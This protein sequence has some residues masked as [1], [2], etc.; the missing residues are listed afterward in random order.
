LKYV[1]CGEEIMKGD[2]SRDS[3]DRLKH[4]RR[5]LMQQGR[6]QLDSD[7]NEQVSILLHYIQTLATDIIGPYA[8]PA[9]EDWGFEIKDKSS[10]FTIGKGR[11]YVN[12]ILCENDFDISY[13]NQPNLPSPPSLD[14]KSYLV[15]LDV[16]E[17]HI[18]PIEDDNIREVALG[19]ADTATRAKVVWQVKVHSSDVIQQQNISRKIVM[20]NWPNWVNW[21]QPPNRGQLKAKGKEQP[22]DDTN[23]CIT[24]PDARYRGAENQLYR[25]EIHN[26]NDGNQTPTFKWSREN[27]SV[28][29]PIRTLTGDKVVLVHLGRD[30]RFGLKEQDWVEIVDDDS[31]LHGKPGIMA[32]VDSID[33]EEVSVTL[34]FDGVEAPSYKEDIAIEKH[35]LLRRWDHKAGKPKNG[36]RTLQADAA[37]LQEGAWLT[38]EDGVQ[39]QFQKT[40]SAEDGVQILF[41]KTESAENRY[42]TGDYWLIPARTATG[43]VEW[44]GPVGKPEA[45]PPHGVEHHYAPLAIIYVDNSGKVTRKHDLRSG[46]KKAAFPV[47]N[48]QSK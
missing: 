18:T 43:D 29:F 10:D 7:W 20:N 39:I 47:E 48:G 19:V 46:I 41:Q 40:E 28:V 36:G 16:W 35:A 33:R 9:E 24:S 23:P 1:E 5:V 15:Y 4:F 38:L 17:R 8:G 13:L 44:P 30:E 3:F 42:R 6:V 27:G 25:V 32:Q 22:A 26:G 34:L 11:Y 37:I 2:F 14:N 45:V 31:V 21:W 12:G